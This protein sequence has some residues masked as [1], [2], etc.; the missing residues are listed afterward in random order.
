M[1]SDVGYPIN[2][3]GTVIVRD[4]LDM[5]CIYIFRRDRDNCQLVQ[6]EV[7]EDFSLKAILFL[8]GGFVFQIIDLSVSNIETLVLHCD[9]WHIFC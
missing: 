5:K 7:F 6:S 1:S 3:Y 2:V 4:R 9:L 8:L